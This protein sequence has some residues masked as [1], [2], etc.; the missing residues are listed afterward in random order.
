[1]FVG[2]AL[3][4][5]RDSLWPIIVLL[6]VL[7]LTVCGVIVAAGWQ[8]RRHL[9]HRQ[10]QTSLA[11][12]SEPGQTPFASGTIDVAAELEAVLRQ[13]EARAAEQFTTLEVTVQAGLAAQVDAGAFRAVLSDLVGGAI[14]QAPCG[15]VLVSAA[16]T[17]NRAQIS[18]ADDGVQANGPGR[19]AS[20]RDAERL[21][22]S[23]GAIMR[24]DARPSE[25]TIVSYT[26]PTQDGTCGARSVSEPVDP[27]LVWTAARGGPE[28]HAPQR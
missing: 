4:E 22:A 20:L 24:V 3:A 26:L 28:A 8:R 19:Q 13:F 1:M 14:A 25:G 23:H 5:I 21:A 18:V 16:L 2:H 17:G 12:R 9:A 27:S 6:L 15:R 10:P 11:Q 7:S